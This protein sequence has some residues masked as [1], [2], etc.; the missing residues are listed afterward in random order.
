MRK[1]PVISS[2]EKLN[3][4]IQIHCQSFG[5]EFVPVFMTEKDEITAFLKYELPEI[6]IINYSDDTIDLVGITEEIRKDPWLFYGGIIALHDNMDDKDLEEAM[7]DQNVIAVMRKREV[8]RNFPRLLRIVRQNKQILFQRGIQQHLIKN[9]AGSF[10]IDNDPLDIT[11]YS[12][13]VT[14]YLFN[15]NLINKDTREKLHVALLELLINAIEHGNCKI[16]YDEKTA[17]LES[18][19]DIMELIREK[20][21]APDIRARKVYFTYTISPELSRFIIRDEGDGFD[22]RARMDI[23][24]KEPEL[25]GMGMNMAR[26]YVEKLSYNEKGNEV[27]FEVEH[28]RNA[29]NV[30]PAI[31]DLSQEMT[32]QD[33]QYICSEGE[34]SDYL[35]YIVSGTLY[36]YSKGKLVSALSPD[37]M[38]MGEMSFLLSNRRSATVVSKGTSVLI[39]IS[40]QDFVNLIKD[41]PH[42]G[43]FL[44]RLLAQR[45]ARLNLRM[46]RLNT[47]YLKV[48]KEL[49]GAETKA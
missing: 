39:R 3:A 43:I 29:S 46:S 25:H 2:D 37:D 7:S 35:Y 22:W 21:T 41:S 42:Y 33:G 14:N 38:F 16:S 5:S 15:A 11:T 6:K 17:W 32:F 27:S 49:E 48:K 28:Q 8:E 47:E 34:E 4:A 18:N 20:N 13:L 9:I 23:K 10:V 19:R 31:F 45:L 44:A 30:I 1:I 24:H 40:K 26:L 12:N 36:V